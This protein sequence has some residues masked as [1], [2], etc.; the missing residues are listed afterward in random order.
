MIG[1]L[2]SLMLMMILVGR[3]ILW[4]VLAVLWG[5]SMTAI[6]LTLKLRTLKL[7]PQATDVAMSLFSGIYNIGIGGGMLLGG[8]VITNQALGLTMIGY[9]G[10]GVMLL[11]VLVYG[12]STKTNPQQ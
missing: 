8:M 1:M 12:A 5:V 2:V 7:A 11:A 3:V 6:S 9:V 4:T 10:A